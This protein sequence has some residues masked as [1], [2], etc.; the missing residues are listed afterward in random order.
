MP[1]TCSARARLVPKKPGLHAVLF[2]IASSFAA[3]LVEGDPD[4]L[5]LCDN[6]DCQWVFYDTTRRRT[7]RWCE[8]ACGNLMK[9][10]RFR[11]KK[12]KG[13]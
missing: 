4:R 3:F 11:A 7:R 13:G 12:R 2:E 5:K 6:P 10:R 8:D 1:Y 9:V